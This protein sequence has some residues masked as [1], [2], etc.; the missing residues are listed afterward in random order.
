MSRARESGSRGVFFGKSSDPKA[1][2]MP[3]I[4]QPGAPIC[5]L[6]AHH[7][8]IVARTRT[9]KGTRV[10]V[11]TLLRYLGSAVVIDP[12]GENAA[13]TARAR[14]RII[15]GETSPVHILNPWGVMEDHFRELGFASARFNPLDMIDR[16]HP[17][18]V[19][20]AQTLANTIIPKTGDAKSDFWQGSAADLLAGVLL[21]VVDYPGERRTLARVR[22]ITSLSRKQLNDILT[23]MVASSAYGGA[24]G[25]L[26]NRF[27]DMA[28]DTY[29]GITANLNEALKFVSDPQLKAATDGNSFGIIDLIQQP[30]TI[31]LIIPPDKIETQR[32]W[33]RL[34]LAAVTQLYRYVPM[35]DSKGTKR[36]PHRCMMLIDEFP[37]LGRMSDMPGD[38][39]TMAGYGI[40][41][42]LIVQGLDQLK[43]TYKDSAGT[44]L[45]NCAFKWFCNVSDLETA[46]YLSETLGKA[47]VQTVG[48]SESSGF[49]PGGESTGAS[50][51]YGETGRALLTP[52][53]VMTLGREKAIVLHPDSKPHYVRPI[54]RPRRITCRRPIGRRW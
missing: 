42:T 51:T 19:S 39:A 32:T 27:L 24:I 1:D 26:C 12:K 11:P 13:I 10:I 52:D 21:W 30:T 2:D 44:I 31:Y 4:E 47:T 41:Y 46:K 48:K 8:L 7:T 38:L 14:Q 53:E 3:A 36:P 25:E 49:N 45:S 15:P 37:A 17:S 40:D 5:S 16:T 50:T 9:G 28:P 34:M 6:P 22:E 20:V 23:R 43:A 54:D 35:I 29:S 18:A 33:L